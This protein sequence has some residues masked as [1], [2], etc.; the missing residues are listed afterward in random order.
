MNTTRQMIARWIA[1]EEGDQD[2]G[3]GGKMNGF[4][5]TIFDV[6]SLDVVRVI[7][8]FGEAPAN[9]STEAEE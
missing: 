2:C 6:K 5:S 9:K 8:D 4:N 1:A 7:E 3:R